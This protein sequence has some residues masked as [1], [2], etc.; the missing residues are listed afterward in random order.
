MNILCHSCYVLQRF[1]YYSNLCLSFCRLHC[2]FVIIWW[3]KS[4]NHWP[5]AWGHCILEAQAVVLV[6]GFWFFKSICF[7]VNYK[8]D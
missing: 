8:H 7:K 4:E 6:F 3:P 5:R 1:K 2:K